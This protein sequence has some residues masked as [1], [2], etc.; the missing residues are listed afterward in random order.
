MCKRMNMG[1]TTI[2]VQ[3]LGFSGCPGCIEIKPCSSF[4]AAMM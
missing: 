4:M 3:G 1:H 2:E